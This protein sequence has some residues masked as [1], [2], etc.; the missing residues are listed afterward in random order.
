MGIDAKANARAAAHFRL[1]ICV[2]LRMAASAE[3]P[4]SP[5]LFQA[6]LR[7]RGGAGIMRYGTASVSTGAD[8]K[9]NTRVAAH[10]SSEICVSLR[11]AASAEV[12]LTPM[13]LY[14]RL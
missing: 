14:P 11:M 8:T 13:R 1:V 5:I 10:S 4:S 2:S 7:A 6:R 3:A 9:A 12:P